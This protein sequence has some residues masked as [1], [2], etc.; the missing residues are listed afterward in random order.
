MVLRGRTKVIPITVDVAQQSI[1]LPTTDATR[2]PGEYGVWVNGARGHLRVG[3]V[4]AD[5][6]DVVERRILESYGNLADA[7]EGR[8]T[9]H[10]FA[11]A[12]STGL[13][14]HE[15]DVPVEDGT[16]PAWVFPAGDGRRWA[17]HLHGIKSSRASALRSVPIAAELGMT[18]LVPAF[19]GDVDADAAPGVGDVAQGSTL[20]VREARDVEAAIAFAVESG[21]EE[22]VLFGWS[23]GATIALLLAESSRFRERITQLVLIGPAVSWRASIARGIAAAR[24]P[25]WVG[26][27]LFR[28]LEA[29]GLSKLGRMAEP[30]SFERLDWLRADRP[31]HVPTLV[32]HSAGDK[33]NDLSESREL[34]RLNPETVAVCEFPPVPHLME[35]NAH[36]ELFERVVR[37]R[38]RP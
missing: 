26:P 27:P 24:L 3:E 23:M 33:D 5:A 16:R 25:A 20:G 9:G 14:H 35:W 32:L 15:V 12:A 29:R 38:L 11:R 22:L 34:A 7:T 1:R 13:S 21:A 10:T 8:W 31:V 2:M 18:S 4:L 17:L 36:R 6:H 19:Y 30:T 28:S 37:E